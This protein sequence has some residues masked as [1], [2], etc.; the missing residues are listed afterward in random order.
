MPSLV[1]VASASMIVAA[2]AV[3]SDRT[4]AD[5][6]AVVARWPCRLTVTGEL[7]VF[8][9]LAWAHSPTFRDQCQKLA[10]MDA[11]VVVQPA[12]SRGALRAETRIRR[13]TDGMTVAISRVRP[14]ENAEEL[15]AHEL[16][17][18]L[19]FAEGLKFLMESS[20]GSS[21]VSLSGG[22]YETQRAMDAGRR[23]AHEVRDAIAVQRID[24]RQPRAGPSEAPCRGG[25]ALPKR[26]S[27]ES[28]PR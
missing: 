2:D 14:T 18:V 21:R 3:A 22:A 17:H 16:E 26:A 6:V 20:R 28:G 7:R 10:A 1:V 4:F 24:T 9:E 15:I 11:V 27:V 19:E 25:N 12:A 8:A 5:G 13:T 23:V